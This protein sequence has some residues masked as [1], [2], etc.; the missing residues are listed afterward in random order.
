MQKGS[1]GKRD[2][3][4]F[5]KGQKTLFQKQHINAGIA[6]KFRGEKRFFKQSSLWL[7]AEV[8]TP[9]FHKGE[10]NL[11]LDL[12]VN[13]EESSDPSS[14]GTWMPLFPL[15]NEGKLIKVEGRAIPQSTE[16]LQE[17]CLYSLLY[18]GRKMSCT[19]HKFLL[20]WEV[21]L[22]PPTGHMFSPLQGK[23]QFIP[24]CSHLGK[25]WLSLADA[26]V[27]WRW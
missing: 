12:S 14:F 4:F 1:G 6:M 11:P 10:G 8:L 3:F 17:I 16:S 24:E 18:P 25:C 13:F 26:P 23:M 7:P 19:N 9:Q 15:E 20:L 22:L 5:F 27:P 21:F 2:S